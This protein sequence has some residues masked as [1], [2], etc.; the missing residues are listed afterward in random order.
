MNSLFV[1][2]FVILFCIMMFAEVK[3]NYT[4]AE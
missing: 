3:K 2:F 4:E 1:A